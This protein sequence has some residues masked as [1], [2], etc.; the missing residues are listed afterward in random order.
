MYSDIL[1]FTPYVV[2]VL[3]VIIAPLLPSQPPSWVTGVFLFA[4]QMVAVSWVA[5]LTFVALQAM[6]A[7]TPATI[8]GGFVVM[9]LARPLLMR[10]M[11]RREEEMAAPVAKKRAASRQRAQP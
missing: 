4:G 1:Y 11:E 9:L 3:L 2:I 10:V 7:P 8:L 5:P 6:H